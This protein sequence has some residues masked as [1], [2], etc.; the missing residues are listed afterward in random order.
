[1]KETPRPEINPTLAFVHGDVK[2]DTNPPINRLTINKSVSNAELYHKNVSKG[3][4]I[5]RTI[6]I[7]NKM[8]YLFF[9]APSF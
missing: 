6:H 5:P 2:V 8:L 7:P 1:M 4:E 9:I 3:M